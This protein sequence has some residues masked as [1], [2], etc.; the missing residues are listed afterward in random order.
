MGSP[1]TLQQLD[2][3]SLCP[4]LNVPG[5]AWQDG[6]SRGGA[7]YCSLKIVWGAAGCSVP[8]SPAST[9][10]PACSDPRA[11]EVGPARP[12][13]RPRGRAGAVPSAPRRSRRPAG[14]LCSRRRSGS[15]SPS[16]PTAQPCSPDRLTGTQYLQE[17][18]SVSFRLQRAV[19]LAGGGKAGRARISGEQ[20]LHHLD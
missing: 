6:P 16:R 14:L 12:R 10:I 20:T 11:G 7:S 9:L 2:V 3:A 15:P 4:S 1:H 5:Q 17:K 8:P 18:H 19:C 13:R